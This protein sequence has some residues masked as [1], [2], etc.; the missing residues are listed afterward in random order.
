[1]TTV[2]DIAPLVEIDPAALDALK[3]DADRYQWLRARAIRVQGSEVWYAGEALDIRVDIGRDH[4]AEQT[5]S[6]APDPY[7]ARR[8]K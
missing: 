6:R 2:N 1:M 5:V 4:V 7:P 3:R 8:G